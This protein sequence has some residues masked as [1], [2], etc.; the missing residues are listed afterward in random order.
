MESL[1]YDNP[2]NE[3]RW[4]NE[5]RKVV[6]D[7]LDKEE[8]RLVEILKMPIWFVAPY[9]ALWKIGDLKSAKQNSVWVISGDLPTDYFKLSSARL[10]RQAL[11]S[12]AKRWEKMSGEMLK[13]QIP[14]NFHIGKADDQ[15]ELG[16]LLKSRAKVLSS[17][18]T[19]DDMWL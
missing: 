10:P 14:S 12:F 1:N 13:G 2:K 9:V 5:Q 19:D 18:A 17:W 8:I 3:A 15:K 16:G 11:L 7:Y 4:L 6:K